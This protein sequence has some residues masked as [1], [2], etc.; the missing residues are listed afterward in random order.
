M[1][2]ALRFGFRHALHAVGAGFELQL[3][4][5]AAAF[6]A[7]DDFLVAAVFAGAGGF[8]FDLPAL[9]FGVARVHAEQVAGEDRRFVAAG[10][11]ADFQVEVA[12][13][14]R[15]LRDQL[16]EQFG[17]ELL[18]GAALALAISS[19]A[20]SRS[21]G[22]L[23]IASAAARSRRGLGFGGQRGRDRLQL[24]EFAREL[25]EAVGV[26][27]H[28]GIGEQAFEFLAAFG[29]GFEFAAQ[30]RGHGSGS[31]EDSS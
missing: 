29:E 12:F 17:V 16:R 20:S 7:G 21:S 1:D 10:A 19:S 22:S 28:A 15:V 24:R 8:D 13:V 18:P 26:A 5:R 3:R 30:G 14:A 2:A 31:A 25:A 11:G 9:A 23:R 6:D 4:V 27:D